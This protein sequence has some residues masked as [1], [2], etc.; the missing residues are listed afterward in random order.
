MDFC[1]GTILLD[2]IIEKNLLKRDV[3]RLFK[4]KL[5]KKIFF[6]YFIDLQ[7]KCFKASFFSP[8]M[9]FF[10]TDLVFS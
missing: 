2:P 5:K 10:I 3:D 7:W 8:S 1:V 4:N 9:I 6:T